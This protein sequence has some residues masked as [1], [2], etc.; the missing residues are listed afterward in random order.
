MRFLDEPEPARGT[1]LP[2]APGI[3]RIVA[4]NP[5]PMTYRGTNTYLLDWPG[6]VAVVDPGPEDPAHTA[7][8]LAAS[9]A[10]IRAVLLTHTHRD[11]VGGLAALRAATGAP[12]YAWRE[13]ADASLE[14]DMPLDDG[15]L[16]GA[17]RALHTPGHASD[18]LC[19]LGPGGLLFSG[20]HVMSWSSTVVGGPDGDMAAYVRSLTRLL[21][22]DAP[23]YL[24]GHGPPLPEPLPFVTALLDHR[25]ARE[26]AILSGLGP[27]PASVGAI[28]DRTYRGLHP[29]LRRAAERNVLA[30][31][32]KLRDEARV[33]ETDAGWLARA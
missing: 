9:G 33:M 16:A 5:G 3:R 21:G 20:D 27:E 32:H 6:G 12:L 15:G 14:P 28:V 13:P 19:F 2:V 7:H 10:P 4:A 22:L 26:Q 17:W 29:S 1:A 31:L 24:P 30:H 25:L 23:L 11:H 18:H 8:I